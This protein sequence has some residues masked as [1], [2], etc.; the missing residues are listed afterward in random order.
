MNLNVTILLSGREDDVLPTKIF[1]FFDK[2]FEL[3]AIDR[4]LENTL[5]TCK[6]LKSVSQDSF[7]QNVYGLQPLRAFFFGINK[8]KALEFRDIDVTE[9]V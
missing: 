5:G 9:V 3:H 6:V 4:N 8:K 7:S 1:P 2:I